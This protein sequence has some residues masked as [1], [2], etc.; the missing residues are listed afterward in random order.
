MGCL[1]ALDLGS[2][3]VVQ[4]D[5]VQALPQDSPQRLTAGPKFIIF[6]FM[7]NPPFMSTP[8]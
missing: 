5:Y 2:D 7:T 8:Y 1:A 4:S 3:T 6:I